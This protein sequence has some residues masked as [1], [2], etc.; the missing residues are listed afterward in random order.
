MDYNTFKT[1]L[2]ELVEEALGPEYVVFL[3]EVPQN[4]G[5]FQDAL[6]IWR[7]G[8]TAVPAIGLKG[9]YGNFIRGATLEE[10]ADKITSLYEK[11]RQSPGTEAANFFCYE[12]VSSHIC[13]RLI[14][15]EKN[16]KLLEQI[17]HRKVLDLAL[18]CYCRMEGY[19]GHIASALIDNGHIKLWQVTEDALF[20]KAEENTCR[21]LSPHMVGMKRLIRQI[22]GEDLFP[23]DDEEPERMY[24]L[25]NKEKYFGSVCFLYPGALE[26]IS[27]FL[28][29]SFFILPSSIHECIIV[30]DSGQF[31]PED[32]R[33]MVQD[34]NRR[35]VAEEEVLSDQ[36]YYYDREKKNLKIER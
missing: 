23:D 12:K 11:H 1:K 27:S 2:R 17:P 15:F 35:A 5:I 26:E 7:S 6:M 4:N 30:P 14:N 24:V 9:Y 16:K 19:T 36:V 18:V 20:E 32:L 22:T 31:F 10:L 13:F 34:V 3:R 21:L 28:K 29:S 33:L 25:T 8:E